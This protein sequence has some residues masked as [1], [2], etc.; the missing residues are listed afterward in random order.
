MNAGV[1][2]DALIPAHLLAGMVVLTAALWAGFAL[3]TKPITLAVHP[4]VAMAPATLHLRIYVP[5]DPANRV[6]R[7]ETDGPAYVRTSAWEIEGDRAPQ[8]LFQIDWPRVPEG[9]YLITSSV[10]DAVG[11][12]GLDRVRVTVR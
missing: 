9:E 10:W 3:A 7:V 11:L 2:Q 4:R 8:T 12:R 5:R 1:R 6:V